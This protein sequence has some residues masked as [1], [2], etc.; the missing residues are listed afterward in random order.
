MNGYRT[1]TAAIA[2]LVFLAGAAAPTQRALAAP[3]L[4]DLS[5][6]PLFLNAAVDPN[7]MVTFDDSGSM[8]DGYVP[9]SVASGCI[10]RHARYYG[11]AFNKQ[12]YNPSITYSPPLDSTGAEY[13]DASFS[14]APTNGFNAA[15]AKVNL[16]TAYFASYSED[17]T[18]PDRITYQDGAT[19]T[20]G[21]DTDNKTWQFPTKSASAFYCT[22]KAAGDPTKD[23]DYTCTAVGAGEQTNFANWFAYYRYRSNTLKSA[24]TRSFGVLD[25]DL[26]VAWQNMNN[27]AITSTTTIGKFNGTRR[28]GFFNFI[29]ASPA[30]GNTPTLESVIRVNDFFA[31]NAKGV[32]TNP[33]W[34]QTAGKELSC[35]QNFHVLV[36][37]GYWNQNPNHPTTA[38]KAI[39]INRDLPDG[40]KYVAS[41]SGEGANASVMW[42]EEARQSNCATLKD[43]SV[44]PAKLIGECSPSYTDLAFDAWGRDLRTDL[45][46]NVPRYFPDRTTGVTGPKVDLSGVTD[47]RTNNEAYWNPA[48]DPASWQHVVQ[49][50]IGFGISGKV[51]QTDASLANLRTNKLKWPGAGN[52]VPEAVDDSWHASLASRGKSFGATDPNQIV[53]AL[54]DILSS[55]VQR[56]G[57]AS[58]LSVSTGIVTGDTLTYQTQFD[59]TD[60]SGNVLARKVGTDFSVAAKPEWD[61]ASQLPKWN[62]RQ[63]LTAKAG[64]GAGVGTAFQWTSLSSAQQAQ[65]DKNPSGGKTDGLGKSRLEYLRG[66]DSKERR[67]SGTFRNR[68]SLFGAVVSS[69][70]SYIGQPHQ[71]FNIDWPVGSP[72]EKAGK[73]AYKKFKDDHKA[74]NGMVAV[75]ANDGMLH[76]LD[77][78]TGKEFFAY[79][80]HAAYKNLNKLTD[81]LY[82]FEPTVDNTPVVGDAFVKGQWRTILV[83]TMRRGGQGVFALDVTDPNVT[84]A[85]AST[86][87]LWDFTDAADADLGYTYGTPYIARLAH[88]KW[89]ALVPAGYNSQEADGTPG[90]GNAVLFVIDLETGTVEKKIDVTALSGDADARGLAAPMAVD[91]NGDEITDLA[92]A[93]DLAGNIWRF[94]LSSASKASWNVTRLFKPTKAFDRPITA[95]PRMLRDIN[96]GLPTVY[97]GTGKFIE[98]TD[99]TSAIPSQAFYGIRDDGSTVVPADLF[100]RTTTTT[101]SDRTVSGAEDAVGAKGWM[102]EFSEVKGERVVA[103]AALR[104]TANEVIFS[105]LVPNGDD[106]CKPGGSS[107]LMFVDGAAG[108]ASPDKTA[109]FDTNGDGK[110][111]AS[112]NYKLVGAKLETM[113]TGIASVISQGGGTGAVFIPGEDK[114]EKKVTNEFEW[115]RRGWRQMFLQNQ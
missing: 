102:I 13:P 7:L 78:T 100:A 38:S 91:L 108:A 57:T 11:S 106:P 8:A 3:A 9:D 53:D 15:S 22:L 32:E 2:A 16:G 37:D 45:D 43:T 68:S 112:D 80:P 115:R 42:N 94:D 81:P 19:A 30:S 88:G 23:A 58:A 76:V 31:R 20:T 63:I 103:P 107:F 69:T 10:W 79:V 54:T 49:Y 21:C 48:N 55:I 111:D 110:I 59:S 41:N 113:I 27:N 39:L 109:Y 61:A 75:G 50:F 90:T 51:P 17:A 44:K 95:Q 26:R 18:D 62:A 66:D 82:T 99:R 73:D 36:T 40:H 24:I 14:A 83:G 52:N 97:V 5:K 70:A 101:G 72:E 67:N 65:L 25:D 46:N 114:I 93:G 33:D 1:Q 89:V 98:T 12:Y 56:K 29:T 6:P 34:D 96:S 92:Y 4:L 47:L 86:K 77:A 35:R 104:I 71:H 64:N 87:V 85:D 105:T 28:T 60:W 74:R 84:E